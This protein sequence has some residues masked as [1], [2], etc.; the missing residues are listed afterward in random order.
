[1]DSSDN[2]NSAVPAK[3]Q[4]LRNKL[5]DLTNKN[6]LLSTKLNSSRSSYIRVVDELPDILFSRLHNQEEFAFKSLPHLPLEE[7]PE[8]EQRTDFQDRLAE[9]HINDPD[10]KKEI[11][12]IDPSDENTFI[13]EQNAERRLRDRIRTELGMSPRKTMSQPLAEHAREHGISP[14]Y[15]LPSQTGKKEHEDDLIQT[16]LLPDNLERLALR[17]IR[18]NREWQEETGINVMHAA[19]GFL[20]WT[21]PARNKNV[22]S[23]LVLLPVKIEERKTPDGLRLCVEGLDDP[24]ERNNALAEKL[25]QDFRVELPEYESN[26]SIEDYMEAVDRAPHGSISHWRVR[27]YIAFG[28]FPSMRLAMYND[29]DIAETSLSNEIVT[30]ILGEEQEVVPAIPA[31]DDYKVDDPSI[32]SQVSILLD[33]ADSSQFSTMVE[34]ARNVNLAVEGP[35]GTGK[36]Q[37]IVNIIG[38]ALADGKK[39]LFVAEKMAALEVVRSRLKHLGI[40]EF[41]LPLQPNHSS[42]KEVVDSL[43]KRLAMVPEDS[44]EN[45]EKK[46]LE[47]ENVRNDIDKYINLI[48]SRYRHTGLTIHEIIGLGI[49]T[50]ERLKSLPPNIVSLELDFSVDRDQIKRIK[51]IA[52]RLEDVWKSVR[53][54]RTLWSKLNIDTQ[55]KFTLDD[56]RNRIAGIS[57]VYKE[58]DGLCGELADLGFKDLSGESANLPA[59]QLKALARIKP[60]R[61]LHS[62]EDS[63]QDTEKIR[64]LLSIQKELDHLDGS[65]EAEFNAPIEDTLAGRL[66]EM[67]E[68]LWEIRKERGPNTASLGELRENQLELARENGRKSKE[69]GEFTR[70]APPVSRWRIKTLAT[71]T[72]IL[73]E[74]DQDL[75]LLRNSA[76]ADPK[77]RLLIE[78]DLKTGSD[79]AGHREEMEKHFRTEKISSA[80]EISEL[81]ATI[82]SGG[83]LSFLSSKH[84]AARRKYMNLSREEGFDKKNALEKLSVLG[85]WAKRKKEFLEEKRLQNAFGEHFRGIDTDF[86]RLGEL[87][88]YCR[89]VE[90]EFG[91]ADRD[92]K[93]FLFSAPPDLLHYVQAERPGWLADTSDGQMTVQGLAEELESQGSALRRKND[94]IE[95]FGEISGCLKSGSVWTLRPNDLSRLADLAEKHAKLRKSAEEH[96][97]RASLEQR[98]EGEGER[99]AIIEKNLDIANVLLEDPGWTEILRRIMIRNE[100]EQAGNCTE[101]FLANLRKAE[102]E[103]KNLREK[104]GIDIEGFLQGGDYPETGKYLFGMSED[105]EGIARHANYSATRREMEREGM[106]R[107]VDE[108]LDSD[109]G[110]YGLAETL[111]AIIGRALLGRV[112]REYP[113]ILRDYSG[114]RLDVLRERFVEADKDFLRSSRQYLRDRLVSG[115]RPPQGNGKGKVS[116]H[117][118]LSL[119]NHEINKKKR[120]IPLRSLIRRSRAALLE[121]KPCWMM[122]PLAVAQYLERDGE[123]FDLCIIDEASQMTPENAMGAL[124]RSKQVM[125]VGDTNQ[126]PPSNFFSEDDLG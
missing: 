102:S 108:L 10:Y 33:R 69:L 25:W 64:E 82:K 61:N 107:W 14:H 39:V 27:R 85:E 77:E 5:L 21:D 53:D 35:P 86:K 15:D 66:C 88:D 29:L 126:L 70:Q 23:P 112:N 30:K 67:R 54:T 101:R 26:H 56:I 93:D 95:R 34:I 120:H 17:L 36:S 58:I 19:F 1:M 104:T 18:K 81:E 52:G 76:T 100:I 122:S 9:A 115:A 55:D 57:T 89:R 99:S 62:L 75:L 80:A 96:P 118:E 24:S 42:R 6:P 12:E 71:V 28:V 32:E 37:T 94:A 91:F 38:A 90:K 13:K 125:V 110:L 49:R 123:K 51:E 114:Q 41:T 105:E 79:L 84:R 87:L 11:E 106:G 78:K 8:D 103:I 43:V 50:G 31:D 97:L 117:T 16:L 7:N 116:T 83:V 68:T 60:S 48:K 46:K 20:E 92:A 59:N 73:R 124:M 111:E 63:R 74:T 40:E 119:I 121:L 4:R 65:M 44:S 2:S 47:F 109:A 72:Q 3:I 22:F 45:Y 98:L 113:E